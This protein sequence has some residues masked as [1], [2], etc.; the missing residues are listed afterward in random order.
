MNHFLAELKRRNVIRVAGL[1]LAG[2]WLLVQVAGTVLPFFNAPLALARTLTIVLAVGFIPVLALAW[3]FEWTAKGLV[4]ESGQADAALDA[5]RT[6]KGFDRL[7]M[8]VLALAIGY[9]A[10]D[11]FVLAPQ[12]QAAVAQEA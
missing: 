5:P 10:F 11:K 4:R 9:F 3:V 7:I 2:A 8:L 12:R 6:G 1:Y